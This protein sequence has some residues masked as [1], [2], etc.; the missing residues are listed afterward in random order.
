M[1]LAQLRPEAGFTQGRLHVFPG[2]VG[3]FV[4]AAYKPL[5]PRRHIHVGLAGGCLQLGVIACPDFLDA[6]ALRFKC[7]A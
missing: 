2:G 1:L 6:A 3:S 7:E 5:H 4:H